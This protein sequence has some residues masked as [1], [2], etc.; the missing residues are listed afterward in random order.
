MNKT[1]LG[2]GCALLVTLCA[3]AA[4]LTP[5]EL[6]AKLSPSI[7]IIHTWDGQGKRL[8]LGSG[9]V[10]GHEQVITNCHVLRQASSVAISRGN[11]SYG[12]ELEFPDAQR[13]LCQLKVKELAAPPVRFGDMASIRIGQRV[14]ALGSPRGYELTLTE[15]IVSSLRGG[16]DDQPVIQTSAAIS[17]GSSGGGLFDAEGRLIGITT[18]QRVDG[19]QLNFAHPVDWV[20]E[21]PQRGKEALAR[22][23]ELE[24]ART[25]AAK[26]GAS[27]A[28][29]ALAPY[30]PSLPKQMPQPG[31]TW[32][33]V[34][35]DVTYRPNDRSRKYVHT[36]RNVTRGSIVEVITSA[37]GQAQETAFTP[38]FNAVYRP[39][40]RVLE[41]APYATAFRELRPGE[42]W[43]SLR[44]DGLDKVPGS[45]PDETP[46]TFESVQVHGTEELKIGA[47]T[48]DAIR[49]EL[50]GHASNYLV[51]GSST[52]RGF[53]QFRQTV[54][55][56]PKV[57][58]I[59]KLVMQLPSQ[60]TAYELESY[61]LR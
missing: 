24:E 47:G 3:P 39:L 52:G 41:V 14:Y 21:V 33:Y 1:L 48:F 31:D 45:T 7:F 56:A 25:A 9:V 60:A 38:D 58:R 59:V 50:N 36:V 37:G 20:R 8:S 11:V 46:Y 42:R 16:E 44:I 27:A 18:W 10:V 53:V 4:A 5:E 26:A 6:F 30:D 13:D 34:A 17:P 19:Q 12:A 35:I 51:G 57:K 32:T 23:K 40:P 43:G 15:G 29:L 54:W 55:Y 28:G 61:S 2:S 49:V 22:R